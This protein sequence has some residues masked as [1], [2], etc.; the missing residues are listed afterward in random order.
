MCK[1]GEDNNTRFFHAC[2]SACLRLNQ[3]RVLYDEGRA[4]YNHADKAGVL[5]RFYS[6]LL[7]TPSL[8]VWE[9]DLHRVMTRV[10]GLGALEAPFFEVEAK[11]ALWAMRMDSS[12]GLD[13]FG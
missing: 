9:F 7:G 5:H 12:L 3:I 8:P 4:L 1:L 10:S 13:W 6:E 11:S 2:P